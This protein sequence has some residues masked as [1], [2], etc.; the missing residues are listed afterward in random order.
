ML[1][2]DFQM[3]ANAG[4]Y[5]D[6]SVLDCQLNQFL[7]RALASRL[8]KNMT[9]KVQ[10]KT[11]I[12]SLQSTS[13]EPSFA[14]NMLVYKWCHKVVGEGLLALLPS[15]VKKVGSFFIIVVGRVAHSGH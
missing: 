10:L 4:I 8:D 9:H 6:G 5:K 15:L 11:S 12:V 1:M 2:H 7:F 3:V 14:T 13:A